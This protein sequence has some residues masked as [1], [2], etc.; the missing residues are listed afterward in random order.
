MEFVQRLAMDLQRAGVDVWWDLSDI[1]GS[2]VWERKIEEGLGSSQYFI[3]VLTPAS[4]DSRWVRREYLSADNNGLKIIPLMLKTCSELP[5]TLRDIQPIDAVGR[6][7]EIVLSDVLKILSKYNGKEISSSTGQMKDA[8]TLK[9]EKPAKTGSLELIGTIAM[10]AFF[11]SMS[12]VLLSASSS[13]LQ[14]YAAIFGLAAGLFL[15]WIRK[16][17]PGNLFKAALSLFFLTYGLLLLNDSG[18]WNIP[19]I[20]IVAGIPAALMVVVLVVSIQKPKITAVFGGILLAVFVL[21]V[22]I[23]LG[24]NALGEYPSWPHIPTVFVSVITAVLIWMD[25]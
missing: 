16:L 14:G 19:A 9:D 7:Y 25:R 18:G 21:L 4:L 3:V 1:Q 12:F 13:E 5:L 8:A 22:S 11:L 17:P 24:L 6:P 20:E 15:L 2:D 10:L 23:H